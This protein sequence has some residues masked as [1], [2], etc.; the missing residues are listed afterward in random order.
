MTDV[1]ILQLHI[2][3]LP[4]LN[5]K[6]IDSVRSS[7]PGKLLGRSGAL[8]SLVLL[9]LGFASAVDQ[10]LKRYFEVNLSPSPWLHFG[11]LFGLPALTVSMQLLL[12]LRANRQRRIMQTL[13]TLVGAERPG[14]FRIGPYLNSEE[15]RAS[16]D[17]ADRAHVKVLNWIEH[18]ETI[19]LYLTGDSGCGK[20]SLLNAF[21]LPGLRERGW[22]VVE[23]RAWQDP[24][25]ALRSALAEFVGTHRLRHRE[26]QS[27]RDLIE[28]SASQAAT[29]LLIVL[30]QFEEFIILGKPEQHQAFA[31]VVS[32]LRSAPFKGARLLLVLRSDYQTFLEDVGLPSL[33]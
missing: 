15:E 16:F 33:R 13:A 25:S 5:Q 21:V 12:E 3:K 23:A 22:T 10:G 26:N 31:E 1:G 30:D 18:S 4:E 14:Y 32:Q 17:R 6:D 29:G 24:E 2:P 11:L 27:L 19:P 9:V 8:L 28:A 20:T 7:L